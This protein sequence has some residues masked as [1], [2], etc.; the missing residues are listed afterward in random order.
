MNELLQ[1]LS[2]LLVFRP[3]WKSTNI[4]LAD[5]FIELR[6]LNLRPLPIL[7]GFNGTK[8]VKR[9][10]LEKEKREKMLWRRG[11]GMF[12]L[13]KEGISFNTPTSSR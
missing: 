3:K 8:V 13:G 4:H 12:L 2:V 10:E 5:G 1:Q 9:G 6:H 7:R 11:K